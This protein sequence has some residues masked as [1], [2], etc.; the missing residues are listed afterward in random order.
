VAYIGLG[1]PLIERKPMPSLQ[2][3]IDALRAGQLDI[4]R[5]FLVSAIKENPNDERAWQWMCNAAK[6]DTERIY[7]LKQILRINPKNE[8]AGQFLNQLINSTLVLPEK[9]LPVQTKKK[10]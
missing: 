7:C 4:A 1:C 9:P 6:D 5:K 10:N 3:G 2:R 8:K